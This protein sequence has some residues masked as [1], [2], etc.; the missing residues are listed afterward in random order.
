MIETNRTWYRK[1]TYSNH[2]ILLDGISGTGKTM[3][4]HI[5]D[6]LPG[7]IPPR[8][9]YQ[10]EH[11][12]IAIYEEKLEASAGLEILQL[13]LDQNYYDS[14][15]S[16]EINLRPSDLSSILKSSK[17]NKYLRRLLLPDG[18]EGERRLT[19]ESEKQFYVVHQ[20]MNASLVLDA[21]PN[22]VFSRIL[23]VR[24]PYY[25]YDHWV[26]Y[27]GLFGNSPRDFTV[28][29]NREAEVPWFIRKGSSLFAGETSENKAA[30]VISELTFQQMEFIELE[31]ETTVIDFER[32]V[33][34]PQ[35][36]L[37][38]LKNVLG[39][40]FSNSRKVLD[41]EN[42]PR[43][44]INSSNRKAIYRRYGSG[45]LHS[46]LSH[47]ADYYELKDRIKKSVSPQHFAL[48]EDAALAYESKFGRWF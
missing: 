44:H 24:H 29:L 39:G 27:V 10:L 34:E 18:Q 2:V 45:S 41:R 26:S 42:I 17:R 33:L 25:L 38:N 37:N 23:C 46:N 48:L 28:T 6:D 32:F 15:I 31:L 12:C 30:I 7:V 14:S 36:Y 3:L 4:M 1:N 47:E 13:L 11:L 21:I 43:K 20:L 22:K 5:I 40:S 9:N 19:H 8:F 35:D 16:R